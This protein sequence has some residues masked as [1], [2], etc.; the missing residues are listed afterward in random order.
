MIHHLLDQHIP[1]HSFVEDV[2]SDLVVCLPE[3]NEEGLDQR[4]KFPALLEE[5]ESKMDHY[6]L[7]SY[8]V[9]NTTLEE[10]IYHFHS[11]MTKM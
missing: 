1:N 4:S 11:F 3:F 7:D 5:I 6:G 8:G 9:S 10:V 2:G